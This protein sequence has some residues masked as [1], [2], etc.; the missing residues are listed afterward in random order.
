MIIFLDGSTSGTTTT[1]VSASQPFVL[2][3][4][5]DISTSKS[6]SMFIFNSIIYMQYIYSF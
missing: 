6:D 2:K 3:C 1:T 5:P 4:D